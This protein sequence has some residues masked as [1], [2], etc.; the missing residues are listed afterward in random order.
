MCEKRRNKI[1]PISH[2]TI[3]FYSNEL[4]PRMEFIN[5]DIERSGGGGRGSCPV[6]RMRLDN[7][8]GQNV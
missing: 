2:E 7:W 4:S 1:S 8:P 3:I 6:R 5:I